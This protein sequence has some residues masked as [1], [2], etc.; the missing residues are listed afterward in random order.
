M[1]VFNN[2]THYIL[3]KHVHC[4]DIPSKYHSTYINRLQQGLN[5]LD[6][7]AISESRNNDYLCV[8][9]TEHSKY[10]IHYYNK[11]RKYYSNICYNIDLRFVINDKVVCYYYNDG[12]KYELYNYR[13]GIF[14]ELKI[15][16]FGDVSYD[17]VPHHFYKYDGYGNYILKYTSFAC[18]SRYTDCTIYYKN[19]RIIKIKIEDNEKI[20]IYK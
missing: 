12:S 5:S 8:R 18:D 10:D 17:P 1:F 20:N 16:T 15:S 13:K 14:H 6:Y 9:F 11:Y 3:K 4:S 2:L 19:D 7:L